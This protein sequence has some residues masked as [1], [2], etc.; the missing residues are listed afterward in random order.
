MATHPVKGA[1]LFLGESAPDLFLDVGDLAWGASSPGLIFDVDGSLF[2][3]F[4]AP[5]PDPGLGGD[6]GITP[7]DI[8]SFA[9]NGG[10]GGGGGKP[11]GGGGG[12]T[13]WS[14]EADGDAGYDIHIDFKGSGWIIDA[15][16]TTGAIDFRTAFIN[17]AEYY[18]TVITA[19]IGS[20]LSRGKIINDL[21]VTAELTTID[22]ELGILGQAGP[23]AVYTANDLT[24][25]GKMQFDVADAQYFY[26]LDRWQDIVTHEL[27]HVLGFGSLWNYGDHLGLV[28]SAEFTGTNAVTAYHEAG[29]FGNIPVETDGGSGTAGSHWDDATLKNELMTGYIGTPGDSLAPN[30]LSKFSVMSLQDLGY[31]M[32]RSDGSSSYIDYPYDGVTIA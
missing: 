28:E 32:M 6:A 21:T 11:P 13:Y 17:A 14:G 15:T 1:N 3:P 24:A 19:D 10:G 16:A 7:I 31:T 27:T 30:Y 12:G 8:V 26:D 9:R 29:F 4:A 2:D 5:P 20:A 25:T 18:T 22:G 23:T